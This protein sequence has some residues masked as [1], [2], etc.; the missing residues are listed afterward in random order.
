MRRT[1]VF[2]TLNLALVLS[3][4]VA[5]QQRGGGGRGGGRGTPIQPGE[6][7][8]AGHDGDPAAQLHGARES[9]RRALSTIARIRR[10]SRRRTSCRRRSIPRSTFTAIRRACSAPEGLDHARQRARQPQRPHHAVG[11]QHVGRPAQDALANDQGDRQDEGPRARARGHQLSER[12]AGLGAEGGRAA[13]GRRRGRRGRRRRDPEEPSACRSRSPTAR[14]SRSTIPSSIRSG[15][16][17]RG[18]TCRCSSTRPTR[19][20]SSSRS[21]TATS[22]GSSSRSSATGAI[23]RIASRASRS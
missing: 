2:A 5:A 6:S 1:F 13:R 18:S 12:R 23:R 3:V 16:R 21:T 20:S 15:T 7:C 8:P 10:S 19:R 14:A 22:G 9:R 17:A 11:R 4:P